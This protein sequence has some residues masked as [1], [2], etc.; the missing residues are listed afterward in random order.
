MAFNMTDLSTAVSYFSST[1][2]ESGFNRIPDPTG[3]LTSQS[4]WT[5]T[6]VDWQTRYVKPCTIAK[7]EYLS[8]LPASLART[9]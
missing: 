4:W 6:P 1:T 8:H 9:L 2:S 5:Y 7:A 3:I